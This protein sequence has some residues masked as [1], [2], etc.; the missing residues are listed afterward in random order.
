MRE[1]I[2]LLLSEIETVNQVAIL[3]YTII[4]LV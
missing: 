1:E 3:G 2:L 4:I